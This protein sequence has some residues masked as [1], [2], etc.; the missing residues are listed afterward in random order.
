MSDT[1]EKKR[2]K[3]PNITHWDYRVVKNRHGYSVRECFYDGERLHSW[4]DE[5]CTP[6]GE[7]A[8]EFLGD[9]DHIFDAYYRPVVVVDGDNYIGTEPALM[10]EEGTPFPKWT[11]WFSASLFAAL[12]IG[13]WELLQWIIS[14]VI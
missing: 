12:I 8:D 3:F 14:L 2:D 7:S 9:V 10:D 13:A 5:E 1:Y 4:T 11:A 6:Y